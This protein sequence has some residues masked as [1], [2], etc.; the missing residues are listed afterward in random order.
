MQ[1]YPNQEALFFIKTEIIPY[2]D[3]SKCLVLV[4][5]MDSKKFIDSCD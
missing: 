3:L 5:G 4:A 2:L 1:Y